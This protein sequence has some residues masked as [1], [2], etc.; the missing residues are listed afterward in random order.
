MKR[1]QKVFY[2]DDDD[3]DDA[4]SRTQISEL[5]LCFRIGQISVEDFE[6]SGH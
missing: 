4:M 3:D 1:C 5:Y 6:Y 2:D